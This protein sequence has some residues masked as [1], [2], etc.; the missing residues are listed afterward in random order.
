MSFDRWFSEQ[1]DLRLTKKI[2]E[3]LNRLD[4]SAPGG[5]YHKDGAQWFRASAYG[6]EKDRVVRRA[7]GEFTYFAAD[8]AYH[9]DKFSRDSPAGIP[10]RLAQ[11]FY[12]GNDHHG[13]VPRLKAVARKAL[14]H[15]PDLLE[16]RL[17]Q[18]VSLMRE[19]RAQNVHSRRA[20]SCPCANCWTM[21]EP[22]LSAFFW[23]SRKTTS[24]WTLTWTRRWQEN[25]DKSGV[26]PAIRGARIDSILQNREN[27]ELSPFRRFPKRRSPDAELTRDDEEI[28]LCE[29]PSASSARC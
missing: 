21:S 5:L 28:A 24:T 8:I 17:I 19:G 15:N 12:L 26:L 10:I 25:A 2:G 11:L 4:A 29:M 23:S 22:T 14:G 6:D 9:D 18:F 13:Y 3:A 16:T 20:L 7:N 1:D 27:P